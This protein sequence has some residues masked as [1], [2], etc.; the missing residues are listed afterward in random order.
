[1]LICFEGY[2]D[3]IVQTTVGG[4]HDEH[5]AYDKVLAFAVGVDGGDQAVVRCLYDGCWTFAYG[6]ADDGVALPLWPVCI[7][8]AHEYSVRLE[9]EAPDDA[10]VEEITEHVREKCP[11]HAE[12]LDRCPPGAAARLERAEGQRMIATLETLEVAEELLRAAVR[13]LADVLADRLGV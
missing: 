7:V 11:H 3:D 6:Q 9:I 13:D 2:S 8:Q 12:L 4:A 5:P 10:K 1:M